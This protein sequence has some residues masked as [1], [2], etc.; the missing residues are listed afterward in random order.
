MKFL[1]YNALKEIY[2]NKEIGFSQRLAI[3]T[4]IHKKRR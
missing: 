3:M 4:L 1:F 2:D